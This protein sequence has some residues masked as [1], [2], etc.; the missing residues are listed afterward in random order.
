[1]EYKVFQI[2]YDKV[3]LGTPATREKYL[4]AKEGNVG[5]AFLANLYHEVATITA[6][7]LEGVFEI[8]NI[9]PFENI[10]RTCDNMHSI[11]VG[12]LI[13]GED[14]EKWIVKPSG[15]EKLFD[16]IFGL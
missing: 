3:E 11:S 5:D 2:D 9:G 12:D 15:F 1:M 10:H 7:S 13:Q 6:D 4:D 8:G 16:H 14:G